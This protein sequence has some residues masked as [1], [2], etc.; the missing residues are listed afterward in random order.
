MRPDL[1]ATPSALLD[2]L[3]PD[4]C[5]GCGTPRG[6][7]AGGLCRGCAPALRG[8][9]RWIAVGAPLAGAWALGDHSGPLG[10][11]VRRG[12]YR[13]DPLLVDAL[14][15]ALGQSLVGRTPHVDVVI[16]VP[17][18]RMRRMR[19]G[20]DQGERLADRVASALRRPRL[21]ALR[22]VRRGVQASRGAAERRASMRGAFRADTAVGAR[23]LLVDDVCTTG[24]TAQACA[25]ELLGAGARR[26]YLA[27]V[28]ATRGSA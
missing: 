9:P 6:G 1:A 21:R 22:R 24:A 14:G 3:L 2:L 11:A 27:S 15:D 26:V 25:M 13:P 7:A 5:P 4:D 10:A 16:P 18:D 19:R 12:K 20:F 28:T 17:V 8:L 23:V